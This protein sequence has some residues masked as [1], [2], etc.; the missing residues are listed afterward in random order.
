MKGEPDYVDTV[1][2]TKIG[3]VMY[4][5][6]YS[7][8]RATNDKYYAVRWKAHDPSNE[9]K[10]VMLLDKAK[11]YSDYLEAI[12]YFHTPGQNFAFASK[13][14][15]IAMWAQGEFPAKWK[16]QG[17]FVMP[18]TDSSYFWQGMIPQDE[19]PH[20]VNPER[21]FV[22]SANQMPTDTSYPYYLGGS[23]P[24]YRGLEINRRLTVMNNITPE[25]MMNLQTDNYNVFAE[26]ALPVLVKN[27][28]VLQLSNDELNYF[29]IL[30]T[31]KLRNDIDS[32]GATLFVLTW[33]SL[34][35]KVWDD[36][37]LRIPG[38]VM[39]PHESTLL[40]RYSKRLFV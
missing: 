32:K 21:G 22:S 24:P 12:K 16:R 20:L 10:A 37:L 6:S 31:W 39:M 18:G 1:A 13:S 28:K 27:M 30:K 35:N 25:D 7:G 17:D 19:N 2:Y 26:M 5:K 4:D 36:E 29:D 8:G 23:Y 15:D 38:S 9:L 14:G 34:E 40:G 33:D 3:P 11:N